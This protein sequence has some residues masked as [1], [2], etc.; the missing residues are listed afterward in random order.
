[1]QT[2]EVLL[3][4]LGLVCYLLRNFCILILDRLE[5]RFRQELI[6]NT[7]FHDLDLALAGLEVDCFVDA[8][9]AYLDIVKREQV[10]IDF[11]AK[12][13]ELGDPDRSQFLN[14]AD[15]REIVDPLA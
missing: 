6:P 12:G 10:S 3:L 13:F 14:V 7:F 1:M 5:L 11:L 4:L 15:I 9:D 2:F 8:D